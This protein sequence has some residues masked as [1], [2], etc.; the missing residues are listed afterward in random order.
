[1]PMLFEHLKHEII[2]HA[3]D[4]FPDECCGAVVD[5]KYVRFKNV[6]KYPDVNFEFSPEDEARL[7]VTEKAKT[8]AIVHSHPVGPALP[9]ANDMRAQ[10]A[11][12]LPFVLVAHTGHQWIY[13]E[14]GD[15]QLDEP[16][17]ERPFV[18]GVFDCGSAIR[19]W[20]WQKYK[21]KLMDCP[22]D[23]EWWWKGE[24]LYA[25]LYM[26][27]GFDQ[28][29]VHSIAELQPGDLFFYRLIG[30]VECH[31]G[32]YVGN[33]LIY[34]HLPNRLSREELVGPWFSRISRWVRYTGEGHERLSVAR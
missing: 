15:H 6:S 9:S 18:H 12:G 26:K 11:S 30:G 7:L 28:I 21:I 5:G 32:V 19:S 29:V 13:R 8:Q 34:H 33:D 3:E 4:A 22:R 14:F 16:L 10:I 23:D 25:D 27:H 24:N 2:A 17:L 20:Y 1:M 31:G